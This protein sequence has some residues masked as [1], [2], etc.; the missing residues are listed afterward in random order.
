M[1]TSMFYCDCRICLSSRLSSDPFPIQHP[2]K[3]TKKRLYFFKYGRYIVVYAKH[4][5]DQSDEDEKSESAKSFFLQ[6]QAIR[7]LFY[8]FY[9]NSNKQ[10]DESF[11]L[12]GRFL[13][14]LFIRG[15]KTES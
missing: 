8:N 11:N 2:N 4:H 3:D 7:F 15:K 6:H 13:W 12:V 9:C 10:F 14:C 5:E 1:P